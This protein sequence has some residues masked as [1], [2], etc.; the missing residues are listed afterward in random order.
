[1]GIEVYRGRWRRPGRPQPWRWR[2]KAR[3]GRILAVSS[4]SYTNFGDLLKAL[5]M[6]FGGDVTYTIRG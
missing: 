2:A 5:R 6:L 1:M 4:E 3:N